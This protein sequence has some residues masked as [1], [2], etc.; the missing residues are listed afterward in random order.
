VVA[1][2][3]DFQAVRVWGL[4]GHVDKYD[5][6][7]ARQGTVPRDLSCGGTAGGSVP[8]VITLMAAQPVGSR[9]D[10]CVGREQKRTDSTVSSR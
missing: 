4:L 8:G 6:D 10:L 7:R 3:P 5:T 9:I 2:W 1:A